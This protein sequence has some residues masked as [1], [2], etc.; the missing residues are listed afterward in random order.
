MDN[1]YGFPEGPGWDG[2]IED[3]NREVTITLDRAQLNV[4]YTQIHNGCVNGFMDPVYKATY[5]AIS[6]A[7]WATAKQEV[8][9]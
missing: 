8:Q 3:S 4:L 6:D 1:K 2:H 7:Y 9:R 5:K